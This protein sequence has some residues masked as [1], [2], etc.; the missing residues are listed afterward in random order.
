MHDGISEKFRTQDHMRWCEYMMVSMRRS[1]H[2]TQHRRWCRCMLDD[3]NKK[4]R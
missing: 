4:V 3:I 1:E 2:R